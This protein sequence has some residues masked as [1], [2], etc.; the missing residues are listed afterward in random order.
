MSYQIDSKM[1]QKLLTHA[2]EIRTSAT[3][4]FFFSVVAM[5]TLFVS[6]AARSHWDSVDAD[7]QWKPGSFVQNKRAKEIWLQGN[8]LIHT[9]SSLSLQTAHQV[10]CFYVN[11]CRQVEKSDRR[12][13]T[14]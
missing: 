3:A 7:K 11:P 14:R 1:L 6:D 12:R 8:R 9:Y 13:V 10:L 4:F 5:A 2:Q